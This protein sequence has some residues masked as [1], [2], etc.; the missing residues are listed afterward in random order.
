MAKV[1][2]EEW[3]WDEV[4]DRYANIPKEEQSATDRKVNDY[5]IKELV[6]RTA[7]QIFE[8]DWQERHG[9]TNEE[10]NQLKNL[11]DQELCRTYRLAFDLPYEEA[12]EDE[13]VRRFIDRVK[14]EELKRWGIK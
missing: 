1:E 4:C 5:M 6:H 10:Y 11:S 3:V 14:A 8:H 9:H 2:I 12:C 7:H 13:M